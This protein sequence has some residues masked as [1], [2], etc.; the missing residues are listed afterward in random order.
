MEF[1]HGFRQWFQ[2]SAKVGTEEPKS[3]AGVLADK[4]ISWIV[5]QRLDGY[6]LVELSDWSRLN[7]ECTVEKCN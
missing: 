1:F 2:V 4:T 6:D 7:V 3:L 5:V